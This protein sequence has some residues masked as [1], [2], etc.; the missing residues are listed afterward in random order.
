MVDAGFDREVIQRSGCLDASEFHKSA[1]AAE[2]KRALRGDPLSREEEDEESTR[3]SPSEQWIRQRPDRW[4]RQPGEQ[5]SG[6][7][8]DQKRH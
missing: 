8:D 3:R 5:L 2:E 4:R 6:S 7:T 1:Q